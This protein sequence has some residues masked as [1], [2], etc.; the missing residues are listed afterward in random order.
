MAEAARSPRHAVAPEPDRRDVWPVAGGIAGLGL[1]AAAPRQVLRRFGL[2]MAAALALLGGLLIWKARPA[3][4]YLLAAAAAFAL[5]AL[6][7]PRVLAPVERLWMGLARVLGTVMTYVV[8]TLTWVLLV[9]PIGLGLRL[10]GKDFLALR[11]QRQRS[12]WWVA[13]EE[14]GPCSRP[15][16]PF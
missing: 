8:L 14:D 6:A 5:A 7:A 3:G 4:P 9:T 11:R 2:V 15:D 12:T 10:A 13:V 1:P 16:K